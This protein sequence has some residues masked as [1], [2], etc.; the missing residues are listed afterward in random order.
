ML[1]LDIILKWA[2]SH[3]RRTKQSTVFGFS[4]WPVSMPHFSLWTNV[5]QQRDNSTSNFSINTTKE[6]LNFNYQNLWQAKFM[7]IS[8]SYCTLQPKPLSQRPLI[9]IIITYLI[10]IIGF[11][12]NIVCPLL[13]TMIVF[14]HLLEPA[15]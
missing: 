7:M 9:M 12:Q 6:R 11:I 3:M 2:Q 10:T 13:I 4:S 5:P 8:W 1:N 15:L 14:S